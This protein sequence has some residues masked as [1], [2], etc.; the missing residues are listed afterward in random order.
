MNKID[1]LKKFPLLKNLT[2]EDLKSLEEYVNEV[3]IN[4]GE[5]II[6]EGEKGDTLYL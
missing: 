3:K 5:D 2:D 4:E 1:E 6:K